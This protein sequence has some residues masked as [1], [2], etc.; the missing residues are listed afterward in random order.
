MKIRDKFHT[1]NITWKKPDTIDCSLYI[2]IKFKNLKRVSFE[3]KAKRKWDNNTI[4]NRI[5]IILE[6]ED[7]EGIMIERE[8]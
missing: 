8:G 1:H 6:E 4:N 3:D 2:Y 5:M 7:V